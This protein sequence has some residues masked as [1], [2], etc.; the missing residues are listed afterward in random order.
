MTVDKIKEIKHGTFYN[1]QSLTEITIPDSV[2]KIAD[3]AFAYCEKLSRI[4]LSQLPILSVVGNYSFYACE[5]LGQID[6]PNN[7]REIGER[8]FAF[9]TQLQ[10]VKLYGNLQNLGKGSFWQCTALSEIEVDKKNKHFTAINNTLYNNDTT[11]IIQYAPS[12]HK[13]SFPCRHR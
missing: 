11:N 8:S 1:C 5:N 13:Q 12:K 10:R 6:F 4:N 9:C 7:V 2:E 3:F